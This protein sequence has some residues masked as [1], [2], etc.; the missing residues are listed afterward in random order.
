MFLVEA[1]NLIPKDIYVTFYLS[2]IISR[3]MTEN[4]EINEKKTQFCSNLLRLHMRY[5]V[6]R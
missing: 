1:D 2:C 6:N 3:F 4:S 5:A